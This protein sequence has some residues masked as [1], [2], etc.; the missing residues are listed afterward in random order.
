M[1]EIK[2]IHQEKGPDLSYTDVPILEAD[3]LYFKDLAREGVLL[4]FEDYRLSPRERAEDLASRMSEDELIG[5][6]LHSRHQSVPSTPK[7]TYPDTY[8]GEVFDETK[9]DPASLT[10]SL[11]SLVVDEHVRHIL[12]SSVRNVYTS[13]RWSNNL[14]S[15]CE[16]QRFGIPANVSTDPRHGSSSS[17]I[18]EYKNADK[19]VSKWPEG[20]GMAATFSEETVARFASVASRE[21]RAMG[22]TTMLGPQ[23]DLNTEPRWKRTEDTFGG[24]VED[25][26]RYVN[27]YLNAMQESDTPSGWGKDSVVAMVKHFP[28]G[29]SGEGGRD[30][31]YTFGKYN[32]YPGNNLKNHLRPFTEAA[33]QLTGKTKAAGATMPYYSI[34]TAV[35]EKKVGNSYNHPLIHDLLRGEIGY[36]GVLCTDWDVTRDPDSNEVD[37]FP[38]KCHGMELVSRAERLFTLIDNGIDQIGGDESTQPLKDGF[39]L[40]KERYGEEAAL[41]RMRASAVRSVQRSAPEIHVF[42]GRVCSGDQFISEKEQREK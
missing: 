12:Q 41:E 42:E 16:S 11:K 22:I 3:G 13:A 36:D 40:Y 7:S 6:M 1:K 38:P 27:A 29:G 26:K 39:R 37:S 5:L 15:L 4:P 31:H 2:R 23:I 34:T 25:V 21:Y 28:G 24:N 32:V 14:Q 10:D 17:F 9:H 33:Y 19:G 30:A 8:D 18:V 35:G 20:I